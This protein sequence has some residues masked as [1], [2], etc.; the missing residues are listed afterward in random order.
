[1]VEFTKQLH[2][3]DLLFKPYCH[4]RKQVRSYYPHLQVRILRLRESNNLPKL[5]Q[6]CGDRARL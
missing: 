4:P 1:M 5:T 3:N 6:L 2:C